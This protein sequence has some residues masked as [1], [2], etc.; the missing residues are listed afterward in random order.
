MMASLE[1][2]D[3]FILGKTNKNKDLYRPKDTLTMF[4]TKESNKGSEIFKT[5]TKTPEK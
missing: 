2:I 3:V 1:L 5:N 4:N